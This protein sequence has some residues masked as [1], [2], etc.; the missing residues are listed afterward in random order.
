MTDSD[1]SKL[2]EL[3]ELVAIVSSTNDKGLRE[4]LLKRLLVAEHESK[5]SEYDLQKIQAEM[6]IESAIYQARTAIALERLVAGTVG[7]KEE[8][9]RRINDAI[10]ELIERNRKRG[11]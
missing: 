3:S 11:N 2:G 5:F 4:L 7:R 1:V 10:G 6:S 8:D 9:E